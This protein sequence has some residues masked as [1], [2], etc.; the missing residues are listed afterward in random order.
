VT[1]G[2]HEDSLRN[3][4]DSTVLTVRRPRSAFC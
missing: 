4:F 1:R 3:A 2:A